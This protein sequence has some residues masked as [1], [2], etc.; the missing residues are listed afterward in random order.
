[1]RVAISAVVST[2]A[3]APVRRRRRAAR[4]RLGVGARGVGRRR[5]TPLAYLAAKTERIGLASGIVQLGARTPANLAMS[6]MSMQHAVGR[7]LPARRRHQ[8]PA[9]D[10]G[11]AR[12][13][14][15]VAGRRRP[16][17]RSRS[18][19]PSP[20][21]TS[22]SYDGRVYQLPLPDGPGRPIRSMLPPTRDPDL[23]RRARPDEPRAHRRAG[24]RLARQRLPARARRRVPR[25]PPGRRRAGR[26]LARRPRPA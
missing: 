24:R 18:S 8:R 6:A 3:D 14:L 23:R 1:M 15:H 9:G 5:P 21:A 26:P 25:P 19:A 10:G 20:A 22:S 12:R 4:G 7:T 11:L 16:A 2:P 13:A 17:R